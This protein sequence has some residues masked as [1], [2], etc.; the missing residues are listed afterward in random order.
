[1]STSNLIVT[2]LDHNT[3]KAQQKSILSLNPN[4][5]DEH[6]KTFAQMTVALTKDTYVKTD[7]VDKRNL[8]TDVK[9]GRGINSFWVP[10]NPSG[11]SSYQ[12]VDGVVTV[13][14]TIS[15]LFVSG[16]NHRFRFDD[17]YTFD[18]APV[19]TL[20]EGFNQQGTFFRA[21]S[22]QFFITLPT[23]ITEPT[24]F[25]FDMLLPQSMDYKAENFHFVV[26]ITAD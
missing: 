8:D 13:P 6:L 5:A 21:N 7:R 24:S 18:T 2:T 16:D 25:E 10:Q 19:F 3:G 12:V 15:Q 17:S 14:R 1:M 23:L 11:G 4:A 26:N 20:P 22:W 9:P